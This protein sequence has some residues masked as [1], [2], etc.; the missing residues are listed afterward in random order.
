MSAVASLLRR[1]PA[2]LRVLAASG[3]LGYGIPERALARGVER[4]PDVIGCDMGSIDP[5][6]A[7]LGS[8]EMAT[9]PEMTRRDLAMVLQAS[10]SLNVP[11]IIGSAGTAGA[12]PHLEATL[13][14]VRSIAQEEDLHFRLASIRA[15]LSVD[16]VAAALQAGELQALGGSL[17]LSETDLRSCAHLVGQMGCEPFQ[18]ALDLEPDV[19]VAGR[20]CDTAV[21]AAIPQRLGFDMAN[22]MHMAKIIECTSICCEPGGR[23]AMLA[24][25]DAT[26][27]ELE[28]MNPVRRATPLSVAAHSLY[29]QADPLQFTE[30]DGTLRVNTARYETV[31]ERRSRVSGAVWEPARRCTIKVEGSA[32]VGQRAVLLAATADPRVIAALRDLISEVERTT[33]ELLPGEYEIFPRLYGLD[34]VVA[35][36]EPGAPP[37]EVL[38]LVEVIAQHQD[39]ALAVAKT[40]KQFLLHQ[41]FRGRLCTGGNLAFPFTP[42]ELLAGPA[43]RFAVYHVMP[44]DEHETLFPVH[45]EQV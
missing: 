22:V 6:P 37:R 14:M 45:L 27:F 23:D 19:I 17:P 4:R 42:P 18:R 3:Q 7:Y 16:R 1:R 33:R 5:G 34:G 41:G 20:S 12:A 2:A 26:G 8:G 44:V 40:F 15:D 29:E 25:L 28:S 32:F 13:Q 30:P 36:P 11:L 10:R 43:Y 21:F 9:S 35:W 39:L 31:D 38:V 24:T